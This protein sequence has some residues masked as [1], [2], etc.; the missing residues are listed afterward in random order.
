[1]CQHNIGRSPLLGGLDAVKT[2]YPHLIEC[3]ATPPQELDANGLP[4]PPASPETVDKENFVMTEI[5]PHIFVGKLERHLM[6]KK[7]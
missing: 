1:M 5:M 6:R 7:K 4:I 3:P 2:E